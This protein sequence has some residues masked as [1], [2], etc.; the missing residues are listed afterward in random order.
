MDTNDSRGDEAGLF[1]DK[2][3]RARRSWGERATP[4]LVETAEPLHPG[5]A[6]DLGCGAGGDTRWLARHGWQVTAVDISTTAV[7]RVRERA[8]ELGLAERVATERHDLARS[9]PGGE[10]DLVCAQYF[11]TPFA[12]PRSRVLRTAA[13][14]CAPAV[15]C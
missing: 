1:W 11:H 15:C 12:L 8:R 3:H 9:F 13:G 7:G 4:L 5:T 14:P 10:F 6:L 2:H